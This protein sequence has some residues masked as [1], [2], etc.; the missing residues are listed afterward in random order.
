MTKTTRATRRSSSTVFGSPAEELVAEVY[1]AVEVE[2]VAGEDSIGWPSGAP[3]CHRASSLC[4][5]S[6]AK[7]SSGDHTP[8]R[9]ARSRMPKRSRMR[10]ALLI[11]QVI[12]GSLGGW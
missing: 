8:M 4:S 7:A 5:S 1:R 3:G 6:T 12:V 2:G 9:S 10:C 11:A